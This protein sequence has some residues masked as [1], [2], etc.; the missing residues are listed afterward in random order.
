[1]H[2]MGVTRR[3]LAAALERAAREKMERV[4]A[5]RVE[6]SPLSGI[7]AEEVCLCFEAASRDT[8]AEGA[9]FAAGEM[10]LEGRCRACGAAVAVT[11]PDAACACGSSDFELAPMQDWRLVAV[12]AGSAPCSPE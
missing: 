5:V 9:R 6:I 1:M 10:A 3:M 4:G 11:S 8:P 2:E 7:D 12:E